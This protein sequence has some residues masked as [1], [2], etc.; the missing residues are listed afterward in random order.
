MKA[1]SLPWQKAG[2]FLG[3]SVNT[4]IQRRAGPVRRTTAPAPDGDATDCGVAVSVRQRLF[5]LARERRE[6]F[7]LV[8]AGYAI[9]RL[10][11]RLSRSAHAGHFILKGAPL[12]PLWGEGRYRAIRDLDLS[13]HGD[14]DIHHAEKTFREICRTVVVDDGLQFLGD[15]VRAEETLRDAGHS[16]LRITLKAHVAQAQV[17]IQVDI[18]FGDVV[19][20]GPQTVELP[21]LLAFP[22]PRLRAH[23]LETFIAEKFQDM[24]VQ[25]LANDR[26]GDLYDVWTLAKRFRFEGHVLSRAIRETFAGRK[27]PL[28]E[29]IPL[30]LSPAFYDSRDKK[31]LWAAFF[32][33]GRLNSEKLVLGE[34]ASFL[35]AFLMPPTLPVSDGK[36]FHLVW[37]PSGPWS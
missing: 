33:T 10:L 2:S 29:M 7:Q 22:A 14:S 9:E 16:S 35:G 8:L 31:T 25:G 21:T 4:E 11:Y 34:V 26:M 19:A 17:D 30:G 15:T 24:V 28:P 3:S 36:P 1:H 5:H 18:R 32:N 6:D 20:R 12:F 37:P 13:G 23:S 27:T